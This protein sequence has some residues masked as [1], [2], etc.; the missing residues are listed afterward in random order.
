MFTGIIETIGTVN[1]IVKD[2]SNLHID[3]ESSI[4]N[5]LKVDQSVSHNGVC[6]TVVKVLGNT[7]RVT[8]I[9]ETLI[10]T[11]LGLWKIG[12]A[13]NLERAMVSGGRLDGHMVQGH[14]DQT[15][16]CIDIQAVEGSWNFTFE[17]LN[18][19]NFLLVNKGSVCIDG[20]S[21]TVVDAKNKTFS[22]SIIPYTFEHT[23]FSKYQV[24]SV[25]NIEFDVIGKYV[26]AYMKH[27]QHAN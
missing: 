17:F 19:P 10:K 16:K 8:A 6:L 9:E 15:A 1:K 12:D 4:S 26:H 20:V 18:E 2:G 24:D 21:L 7:Y 23:V 13:I 14:V 5:E 27:Y 25:V 22:V 11:N 3:L